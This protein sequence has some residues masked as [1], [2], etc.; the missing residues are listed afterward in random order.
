MEFF[1]LKQSLPIVI[2][3]YDYHSFDDL[4]YFL[5]DVFKVK[6]Y[7]YEIEIDTLKETL[8]NRYGYSGANNFA[9]FYISGQKP[10]KSDLVEIC[11]NKR[12]V[13]SCI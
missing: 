9:V 13:L 5:N 4:K 2:G 8:A 10:N 12:V 3:V 7:Y 11:E 6:I 1:K